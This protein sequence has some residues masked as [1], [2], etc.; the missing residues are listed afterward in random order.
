MAISLSRF[1][2]AYGGTVKP[3]KT[4]DTS[5][6][7]MI[8]ILMVLGFAALVARPMPLR[9]VVVARSR[10]TTSAKLGADRRARPPRTIWERM[11]DPRG[12]WRSRLERAN[13]AAEARLRPSVS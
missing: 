1:A 2:T 10:R 4:F 3:L 7:L 13:P 11:Q 9:A 5:L 12:W 8:P 6:S